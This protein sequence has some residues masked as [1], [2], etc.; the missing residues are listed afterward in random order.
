MKTSNILILIVLAA[1]IFWWLSGSSFDA[2]EIVS[3][4]QFSD[5]QISYDGID[6]QIAWQRKSKTYIGDVRGVWEAHNEFAPFNTHQVLI[7]NGDFSDPSKVEVDGVDI[8][9]T[10]EEDL[11]GDIAGIH[12]VPKNLQGLELLRSIEIGQKIRITGREEK[13]GVVRGSDGR[14]I[15]FGTNGK[16]RPLVL[17]ERV[18][19][20]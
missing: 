3:E 19:A 17:V 1:G 7:T 4:M 16:G 13:D 10:L 20:I 15:K 14:Y 8:K 18:E 12:L 9:A 2:E 5:T 11:E 6:Y